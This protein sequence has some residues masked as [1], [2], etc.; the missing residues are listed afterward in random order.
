MFLVVGGAVHLAGTRITAIPNKRILVVA[1]ARRVHCVNGHAR[2][3]GHVVRQAIIGS[4][5]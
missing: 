1:T 5:L 4:G 2:H 3:H